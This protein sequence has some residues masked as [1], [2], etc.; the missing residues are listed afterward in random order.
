MIL[1]ECVAFG[2]IEIEHTEFLGETL[3]EIAHEKAGILKPKVLAVS[4]AQD[5]EVEEVLRREA[6]EKS[7]EIEFCEPDDDYVAEDREVAW[8]VVHKVFPEITRDVAQQGMEKVKLLV[9]YERIEG[10]KGFPNIPYVLID[11]AHTSHSMEH[12]LARMKSD[13]VRGKLLFGCLQGKN[14]KGMVRLIAESGIFTEIYLTRPGDFRKSDL[15]EIEKAFRN[16]GL[17][18]V[19][20]GNYDG[21]I[22]EVL[23]Q[24]NVE[25]VP[26]IVL[27]SVYLAGEVKKRL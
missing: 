9:R 3:A 1:P 5:A 27:G 25:K 10:V 22:P 6:R 13:G 17:E 4:V 21:F 19:V 23:A 15:A 14:V 11:V 18:V 24:A 2:P 7:A 8:R 12:V 16:E 20:N 26:L